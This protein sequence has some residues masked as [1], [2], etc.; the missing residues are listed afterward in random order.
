MPS[1]EITLVSRL[2]V[3]EAA[4]PEQYVWPL[5]H[6]LHELAGSRPGEFD[7]TDHYA[8]SGPE[9]RWRVRF[10][11]P[12]DMEGAFRELLESFCRENGLSLDPSGAVELA[13]STV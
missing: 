1:R 6:R 9:G 8:Y 12:E 10:F 4:V 7:L 5:T 2:I 3:V 13:R 11:I